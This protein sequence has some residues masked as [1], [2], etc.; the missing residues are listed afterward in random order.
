MA[1]RSAISIE[2]I[3][4]SPT[5]AD[6]KTYFLF[7]DGREFQQPYAKVNDPLFQV[8]SDL[9]LLDKP[10]G[11]RWAFRRGLDTGGE[12]LDHWY[13]L[14]WAALWEGDRALAERAWRE[15]GARDDST[16]R[17][18]WL[19]KAKG[20]LLDGDTLKARREL[21]EAVRA[22]IGHPEAHAMLG[23]LLTPSHTKYGLLET[24]VASR[25][26]P[27]DWLARLDL[28]EG[29]AAVRLDD[30]ASRELSALKTLRPDWRRE[31]V[32]IRLDSLLTAR[33]PA[34]SGVIEFGPGGVR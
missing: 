32:A 5:A 25:L 26:K 13:W 1:L 20:S 3:R 30:A 24:L 19:R 11:A 15:W 28:A 29:L 27:D 9:L 21:L 33:R 16:M 14:G 7:W 34:S 4:S 31:G 2:T 22:G 17:I 12:R 6:R 18:V 10:A 23:V 8:G